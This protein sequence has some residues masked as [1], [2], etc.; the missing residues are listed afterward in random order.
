MKMLWTSI[1]TGGM[2]EI[3]SVPTSGDHRLL[4]GWL[5]LILG[6][7]QMAFTVVAAY[8]LIVGFYERA[9]VA[10]SLATGATVTSRYLFAGRPDPRLE[11]SLGDKTSIEP[12]GGGARWGGGR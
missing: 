1:Q 5:R 2:R 7:T 10:A 12:K 8:L 11:A 9:V 3:P 6:L 4:W